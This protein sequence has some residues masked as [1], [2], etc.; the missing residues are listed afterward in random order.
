MNVALRAVYDSLR[1][2]ED[3]VARWRSLVTTLTARV[4]GDGVLRREQLR[5]G[6]RSMGLGGAWSG[7]VANLRQLGVV[8]LEGRLDVG[9]ANAVATA[10]ELAG[11]SFEVVGPPSDWAPVAT[12]PPEV[13]ALLH[14]PPLRQTAGVFLELI[15]GARHRLRLAMP[16]IDLSGVEFLTGSLSAAGGRGVA[17]SVVT[18][19]GNGDQFT[20]LGDMWPEGQ[21]PLAV[22]EVRTELSSL[23]SHAKVLV[24]DDERG[25]VGSANLTAAGLGRHVEIGV[26]VSGPQVEELARV[27]DALERA[28]YPVVSAGRRS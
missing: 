11:D 15:D 21:G 8:T 5:A 4:G 10:L 6:L 22:T 18:S 27:F 13:R 24:A 17:V 9:R 16:F 2:G 23:G 7:W 19:A 28:G 25:Y 1:G 14:P 26:E 12:L 3:P 20:G